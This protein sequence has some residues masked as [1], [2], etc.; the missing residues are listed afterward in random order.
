MFEIKAK[1]GELSIGSVVAVVIG[2]IMVIAIAIPVVSDIVDTANL[3]GTTA[4]VAGLLP[5]LL[6][7]ATIVLVTR[8]Y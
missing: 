3:T 2:L 4:V 5:L 6:V 1:K 7:V 8:L